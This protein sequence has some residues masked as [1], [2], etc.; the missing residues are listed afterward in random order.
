MTYNSK[1]T[2]I[3]VIANFFLFLFYVLVFLLN[4]SNFT[5]AKVETKSNQPEFNWEETDSGV[6]SNIF[7]TDNET[8]TYESVGVKFKTLPLEN[9][10]LSIEQIDKSDLPDNTKAQSNAYDI[11]LI[12]EN[13]NEVTEGFNI[14]V[15][16][17]D[18][19]N[20]NDISV[21]SFENLD[22]IDKAKTEDFDIQDSNVV[23]NTNHL[24]VFLV[25]KIVDHTSGSGEFIL[26]DNPAD[27]PDEPLP[28]SINVNNNS[29]T[30]AL[31]I[32]GWWPTVSTDIG[33]DYV[34]FH[35][36]DISGA[37]DIS[38]INFITNLRIQAVVGAGGVDPND[39]DAK[40]YGKKSN[41]DFIDLA[42]DKN[43][44][45]PNF[46][47]GESGFTPNY[48]LISVPVDFTNLDLTD[49]VIRYSLAAEHTGPHTGFNGLTS[50]F[51]YGAL[52]VNYLTDTTAPL[53]PSSLTIF[54][55]NIDIGCNSYTQN[56]AITIDWA[57]N[58]EPDFD[59]YIY[60]NLSGSFTT[61]LTSSKFS[62]NIADTDGLYGYRVKAVDNLGNE[63]D[64][65]NYCYITLDRVVP[66][67]NNI[68]ML[69]NGTENNTAKV[70][71]SVT[72][73][74]TVTDLTSPIEK[75]QLWI[76]A[77]PYTGEQI[78]SGEMINTL[79]NTW[80]FTFTMPEN[81]Q[82]GNPI[83]E[84]LLANYFN[85]R[86]YDMAQNSIIGYTTKFTF[87]NPPNIPTLLSPPNGSVI[88][89]SDAILDWTDETDLN[90]PVTYNYKSSWLPS[91]N[92]GPVSTG[93]T[94]QIDATASADNTYNWQVQACDSFNNC[95]NWTDPFK[96]TIDNTAP[97]VTITAPVVLTL[98]GT[99]TVKGTVTDT[100]PDHYYTV[101]KN[102]S[103][104]T[105]AGPG[106]VYNSSSFTDTV[107]FNWDTTLVPDGV[108]SI[109]LEA[110][111]TAGNKNA[112]S[113]DVVTV[114]VDNTK[115]TV[116]LVFPTPGTS[117]KSFQA[118]FSENV[119]QTEAENP[120]NYFLNNWPGAGGSGNL[121]GDASISYN[122][123]TK[124]A[125]ITFTN[126][127]WYISPE[128]QWGVENIHDLVGNI[129]NV[130]PYT[131]YSTPM[132][133]PVTTDFGI[134]AN[135]HNTPITVTL[136]CAD[137][138]G[139]GCKNTYYTID[140]TNPNLTSL[141][142]NSFTLNTEGE[143]EIKY[144]ST[145]K[146]GNYESIK[147][148][149]NT[150]KIDTTNPT[151]TVLINNNDTY[152]N[153][154]T[155]TLALTASDN[156]SGVFQMAF[157]NDGV[158][159][160]T[161][162]T[163]STLKTWDLT[164]TEGTKT[165]YIK[166]I[167]NA[168]NEYITSDTIIL[169]KTTPSST[170]TLPT[171]TSSNTT[172]YVNS[173]DGII[174]GTSNDNYEV[175]NVQISIKRSS[176]NYYFDG[177]NWVSSATEVLINTTTSDLFA[178]WNYDI[179]PDP[180]GNE[181][182]TIISHA[183]D[184][185]GNFESSYTVTLVYDTTIPQ[186]NISISPTT[187]D[188]NNGI[189]VSKPKITLTASDNYNLDY[190]EYQLNSTSGTWTKYTDKVE[191]DEGITKFYYKSIDKAGNISN[192]GLKNVNVDLTKPS[193]IENVT[194]S[195][196]DTLNESSVT[197]DTNDSDI[198]EIKVYK[199]ENSNVDQSSSNF[200]T[201][202]SKGNNQITDDHVDRGNTYYYLFVSYDEAGNEGDSV[203]VSITIPKN[204]SE[205][206]TVTTETFTAPPT[207]IT[208]PN[209]TDTKG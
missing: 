70:G 186:V 61:N 109:R 50:Y 207:P 149:T 126:A 181:T 115:P 71:D 114:T 94:S 157:S 82:S 93:T 58:T 9:L 106:T 122:A 77:Y 194:A 35:F 139:S 177:T 107:L 54:Q 178:N 17:Y 167:D 95:S 84:N 156:L 2:K 152:T 137:T 87:A 56:R 22:N 63:S 183:T 145:D 98:S 28:I 127:G 39:F 53:V 25:T 5:Y 118:V 24:T 153:S 204:E 169:D 1:L 116:D 192:I 160:S 131:K 187:P 72:I 29:D 4:F 123:L 43:D 148:A 165:V 163:F 49:F 55:N 30:G 150:V 146:A 62:G 6:I 48:E 154:K 52:D 174:T 209:T 164:D 176:D 34:D 105:V 19:E 47:T 38:T 80:E 133:A 168:G 170:I 73:S 140:G 41:G 110:R 64:W 79:G 111:D 26:S 103:N 92:Y 195:F 208:T 125:T 23:V 197:W 180:T 124:T 182:Y 141:T 188:G 166:I 205:N 57:D 69:V 130:N 173:W 46:N 13:N 20:K 89:G 198:Y 179:N 97:N 76:I 99:I 40:L 200:F 143:Y 100:N 18:I 102:S 193:A 32:K 37:T 75:V 51:D 14:Q 27:T 184:S 196:N 202:V 158:T 129:Q 171:N 60:Q 161:P 104:Q 66:T 172:T 86:P 191:I 11:K 117:A 16:F 112:G 206:V 113:V 155:V 159:Y 78:T 36:G 201:L 21:V 135:W 134:D 151:A 190:I 175:A 147:T 136:T 59:H 128:Q 185:A 142:G 81:Y 203:K 121:V 65:T 119:N 108:Y 12:D 31:K 42:I 45:V 85:F 199:S 138:G 91:G 90:G 7:I 68:K 96:V 101:I 132:V 8:Y 189:Y 83:N 3:K 144:F 120:A 67:M 162:E 15:T 74:A 88:T 10:K 44:L 33:T